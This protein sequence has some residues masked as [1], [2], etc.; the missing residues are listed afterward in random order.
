MYD[1]IRRVPK[2]CMA[3]KILG[4]TR[5]CGTP[6]DI[7]NAFAEAYANIKPTDGVIVGMFPKICDQVQRELPVCKGDTGEEGMRPI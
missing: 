6:A 3:F 1:T 4:A 7:R 2:P 5:R